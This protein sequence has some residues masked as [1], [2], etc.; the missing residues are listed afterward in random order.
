M[1]EQYDPRVEQ[2]D[3]EVVHKHCSSDNV[4]AGKRIKVHT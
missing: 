2:T 1:Q 4:E 3:E